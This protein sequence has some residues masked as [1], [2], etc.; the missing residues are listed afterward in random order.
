MLPEETIEVARD[1]S[2]RGELVLRR[3]P[4]GTLELRANGVFVMDTVETSTERALAARALQL[5][6]RPTT[7]LVGGLG[8]GYTLAAV[9]E[10]DRVERVTVVEI[11]PALV[12]WMRDGTVPGGAL[13]A[14]RRVTATVGDVASVLRD[15]PGS[16]HDLV[17]LDVDNGPGYLVHDANA[18][19]YEAPALEDARR[20]TRPGGTVV[21]WS[22]A[23]APELE[24]TMA[25][26]FGRRRTEA[27]AYDVDLQGRAETYWLYVGHV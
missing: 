11:E 12:G 21:V 2:E 7:V 6:D 18:D 1:S 23:E 5:H 4:D 14:D 20:A 8:L 9:L 17:L 19:L 16:A 13:L 3:R 10:D 25:R 26:V 27:V 24:R 22:A 15:G